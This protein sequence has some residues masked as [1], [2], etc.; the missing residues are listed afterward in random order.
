MT[1]SPPPD[2]IEEIREALAKATPGPWER[3]TLE[4]HTFGYEWVDAPEGREIAITTKL[5]KP[6]THGMIG[7]P[8][9]E[10]IA[11][12]THLIANAPAWLSKLCTDNATLKARVE[13]LEKALL[14]LADAADVVGVEYFDTDTMSPEVEAMQTATLEARQALQVSEGSGCELCDAGKMARDGMHILDDGS[15]T[16][17]VSDCT[18]QGSAP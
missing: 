18:R 10:E 4:P 1:H 16:L 2:A 15:G 6:T 17:K 11:A 13:C 12:N 14:K 8:E 9:L 7:C 3:K 5:C